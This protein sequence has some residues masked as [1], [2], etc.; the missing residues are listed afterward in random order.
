MGLPRPRWVRAIGLMVAAAPG[1]LLLELLMFRRYGSSPVPGP[2][3]LDRTVS[4]GLV[5]GETVHWVW[6]GD[7]LSAGVGADRPEETFP[8]QTA[9]DVAVRLGRDVELTCL[10]VPGARSSDVLAEQVPA[11]VGVLGPGLTAVVAVGSNDVLRLVRPGPFRAS[12]A[13]ILLA[14]TT[15]GARVVAVGIPDLGSMMA[16]MAEPLRAVVGLAG[17][18]F[19]RIIR[20]IACESGACYVAID[21]RLAQGGRGRGRSALSADAWHPNGHGYDIWARRVADALVTL[22][23]VGP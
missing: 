22:D 4:S 1:L 15:T 12:Y 9:A 13:S 20:D 17:R 3:E 7:S 21:D 18:H 14:L 16:V 5:S 2:Y 10:A 19:D 23:A 6:L 8:S 11:A